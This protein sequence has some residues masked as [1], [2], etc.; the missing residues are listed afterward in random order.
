[1]RTIRRS[2]HFDDAGP[3][4]NSCLWTIALLIGAFPTFLLGLILAAKFGAGIVTLAGLALATAGLVSATVG[5][6]ETVVEGIARIAAATWRILP[7]V[8][9]GFGLL[10]A[11][12]SASWHFLHYSE[13]NSRVGR[14]KA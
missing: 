10:L 2:D 6:R 5:R 3:S 11:A 9:I 4:L 8:I 14:A 13:G 1:M 12:S 7:P